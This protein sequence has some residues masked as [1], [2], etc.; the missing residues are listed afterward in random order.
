MG[1][2]HRLLSAPERIG[3][4]IDR[5]QLNRFA[6]SLLLEGGIAMSKPRQ[7]T[8]VTTTPA[9]ILPAS[10]ALVLLAMY[11]AGGLSVPVLSLMLIA[12]GAT[13]ETLPISIGIT[14]AVTCAFEVP[15][16]VISDVLGRRAT[17]RPRWPEWAPCVAGDGG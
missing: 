5:K 10:H 13:V 16:G 2:Q 3:V 4:G 11:I 15:S 9:S 6:I 7:I 1:G 17:C 8:R 14:L 12:R